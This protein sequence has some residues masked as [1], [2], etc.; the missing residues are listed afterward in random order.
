MLQVNFQWALKIF[1]KFSSDGKVHFCLRKWL[2][3]RKMQINAIEYIEYGM[4]K[5]P[6][7]EE[8]ED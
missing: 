2:N 4:K 3:T 5:K 6:N 8:N 1:E 7:N